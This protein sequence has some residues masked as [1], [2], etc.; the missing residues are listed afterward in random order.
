[1]LWLNGTV[2]VRTV[3]GPRLATLHVGRARAVAL[4]GSRL[5]VLRSS[6]LDLYDLR[7]HRRVS[8][9]AVRGATRVDLQYGVAAFARGRDAVVL[10]TAT[11]RAAVVGRAPRPL[12]GVQIEGPGLAYAWTDAQ[13]GVAQF[14]TTAQLDRALGR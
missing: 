4:E 3:E 9:F 11:G 13:R 5:A 8:S 1:M 2:E 7:S 14:V 12:L 6:R 10:D